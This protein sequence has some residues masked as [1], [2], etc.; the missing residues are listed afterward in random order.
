MKAATL[1]YTLSMVI[2]GTIGLFVVE[3]GQSAFVTVFWRCLSASVFLAMWCLI[4]GYLRQQDLS[5]WLIFLAAIGGICNFGSSLA[6]TAAYSSTTVATATIVYH[7]QPFFVVLLGVLFLKQPVRNHEVLWIIIAFIGTGL[8]TGI[9]G[10]GGTLTASWTFGIALSL[11]AALL[12]AIGTILGTRLGEQR[13]E[14]TTL[15]QAI[16]ASIMLLPMAQ[17]TQPLPRSVVALARRARRDPYWDRL[18][19]DVSCAS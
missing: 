2:F 19:T 12:Y 8:A 15:V 4:C 18:H 3:G 9:V 1:N 17:I 14:V 16:V 13:P 5:P 11:L 7:V 10:Q 6:L